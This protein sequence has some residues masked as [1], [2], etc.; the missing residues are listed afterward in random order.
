MGSFFEFAQ[1]NNLGTRLIIGGMLIAIVLL[2][3]ALYRSKTRHKQKEPYAPPYAQIAPKKQGDYYSI[4]SFWSTDHNSQD[5]VIHNINPNADEAKMV[6]H[7]SKDGFIMQMYNKDGEI[8][9][10]HTKMTMFEL[11]N[12][13]MELRQPPKSH[14]PPPS[15]RPT[16]SR[17]LEFK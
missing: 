5:L 6:I 10:E 8:I 3:Y 11:A 12:K 1:N 7:K 2:A 4:V 17:P 9:S 15:K 14:Q 16:E 13:F